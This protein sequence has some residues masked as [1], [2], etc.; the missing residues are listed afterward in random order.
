MNIIF[1]QET[2][3]NLEAERKLNLMWRGKFGLCPCEGGSRGSLTLFD[4]FWK[5]E[6]KFESHCGRM[7]GLV[8]YNDHQPVVAFI[9]QGEQAKMAKNV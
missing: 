6:E 4:N 5:V 1:L 3:L 7:V 9:V 8:L 2:H